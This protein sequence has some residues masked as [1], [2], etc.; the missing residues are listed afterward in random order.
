MLVKLKLTV[1]CKLCGNKDDKKFYIMPKKKK[2]KDGY[3]F[4]AL[5][6]EIVCKLC[7]STH[8]L[9]VNLE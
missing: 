5:Q 4:S 9:S 7:G 3:H 8:N 6:Y 1:K 2:V